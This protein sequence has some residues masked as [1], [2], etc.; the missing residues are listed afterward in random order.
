MN[1]DDLDEVLNA[2]SNLHMPDPSAILMTLAAA[3]A[4]RLEGP[5][6]HLF[7]IGAPATGKNEILESLFGL[8]K[9]FHVS[10]FSEASLL[11]ATKQKE[12]ASNATGGI[13][14][15]I[16]VGGSGRMIL[17]EFN[18]ILSMHPDR[19]KEA[20]TAL[21]NVCTGLVDR[22]VGVDGAMRLHWDGRVQV[23]AAC[24]ETIEGSLSALGAAGE[25]F[26]YVRMP[27]VDRKG[28]I[29]AALKNARNGSASTWKKQRAQ[30]VP[31]FLNN[32][33]VPRCPEELVS[34]ADES[35]LGAIADFVTLAR[36]PVARDHKKEL[37]L[38]MASEG[39]AR[40]VYSLQRL[41]CGM[42]MIGV[43]HDAALGMLAHASLGSLPS[44]RR[45]IIRY[46]ARAAEGVG[47]ATVAEIR[48]GVPYSDS[49]VRRALE[50][51]EVHDIVQRTNGHQN[52]WSFTDGA[53]DNWC[54]GFT[55]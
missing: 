39:P 46:M 9:T 35:R 12:R 34:P 26:V 6:V 36:S 43:E 13:L 51:L 23:M 16:G 4:A 20:L 50:D 19:K 18:T 7:L 33:S 29:Q 38:V 54:M 52:Y 55:I 32:L 1:R 47:A 21:Q 5:P 22:S 44:L 28:H 41:L 14:M 53:L 10:T 24:T 11:S 27:I 48:E 31:E 8:P 17:T 49:M 15:E 30:I 3:A 2:F 45:T 25:R 37:E 40:M 42:R